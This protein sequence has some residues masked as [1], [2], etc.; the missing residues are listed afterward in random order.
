MKE[1]IGGSKIKQVAA[2]ARLGFAATR[3]IFQQYLLQSL[4]SN[5][6]GNAPRKCSN[7]MMTLKENNNQKLNIHILLL[8]RV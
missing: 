6:I 8:G 3:L 1:L 7:R 5:R 4:R 2:N